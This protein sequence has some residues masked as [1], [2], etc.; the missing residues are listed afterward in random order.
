MSAV[1]TIRNLA[2]VAVLT[3]SGTASAQFDG[4]YVVTPDEFVFCTVCHGVQLMG[5][6]E[7]DAPRLSSMKPWYIEQQLQA[8]KKGWRGKHGDDLIGMEMQ[9]MAAALTDEQISA[10][11]AYVSRTRSPVPESTIAGDADAGKRHYTT[12]AACHGVDAEGKEAL[13][14]PALTGINDW[15]LVR[16]LENYRSG[17]RGSDPADIYGQQM[18][19][20]TQLLGDDEAIRDVV[21]YIT[22]LSTEEGL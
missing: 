14:A 1:S 7:I 22:T 19:A 17:A 8:F 15:Y 3:A 13:G 20:S 5:N 21:R 11:A 12:C 4:D 2:A 18:R 9:P 16:Q 6:R 10:V